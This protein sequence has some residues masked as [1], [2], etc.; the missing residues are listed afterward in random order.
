MKILVTVLVKNKSPH[1]GSD[2][3]RRSPELPS[4]SEGGLEFWQL[5]RGP[6]LI[7]SCGSEVCDEEI[8]SGQYRERLLE[9]QT[10][11]S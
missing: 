4:M 2:I 8:P 5:L 9:A 3:E 7:A 11:R 10:V 1:I 6:L